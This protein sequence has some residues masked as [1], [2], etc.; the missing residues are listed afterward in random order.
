MNRQEFEELR[1]LPAKTILDD[2]VFTP[3]RTNSNTLSFEGIQVHNSLGVVLLLNG[4][5][6]PN[7]PSVKFNF[8]VRSAGGPI[9]RVCVNGTVHKPVGRT[10]K[11]DLR[12]DACPRKQLPHATARPDLDIDKQTPRE[13]WETICRE[14]GIVHEGK[15]V[16]P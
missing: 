12:T 14:A 15:F 1:N 8:S 6:T 5:Y 3:S 10:H 2:I 11:H 13:I 7:I 9:C 4:S 16:D